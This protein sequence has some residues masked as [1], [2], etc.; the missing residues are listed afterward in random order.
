MAAESVV[1][2]LGLAVWPPVGAVAV[3]VGSVYEDLARMGVQYGPVFRG[4]RAVWR[5]LE[6]VFA[7]VVLPEEVVGSGFGV[8]P[9]LLDAALHAVGLVDGGGGVGCGCRLCG[10]GCRCGRWGH[11]CCGCGWLG[12]VRARRCC[13]AM[14]WARRWRG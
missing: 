2:E 5:G 9:A 11:R 8:H 1:P 4:L 12:R 13:C 10:R 7:E 3:D 6:E 14:G